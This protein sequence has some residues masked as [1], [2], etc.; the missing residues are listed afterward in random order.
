MKSMEK[1]RAT[2]ER[3]TQDYKYSAVICNVLQQCFGNT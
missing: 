1:L 3:L 2:Y